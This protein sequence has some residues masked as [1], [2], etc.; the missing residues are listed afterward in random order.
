[1]NRTKR[2]TKP[3]SRRG[4]VVYEGPSMIGDRSPIVAILTWHSANRKTGDLAQ[5]WIL[6]AT[7]SPL[8]AVKANNNRGACGDCILQGRNLD[9]RQIGRTCYVNLGQAPAA[10]FSAWRRGLYL[11]WNRS[12]DRNRLKG[13][14]LRLGAYGDPAALPLWLLRALTNAAEFHTGYTHQIESLSRRRAD[15]VASLC[16]VSTETEEQRQR[17]NDRGYRTFHVVPLAQLDAATT[18]RNQIPCP[19]YSH[20]A[21]CDRCRLCGG[22]SQSAASIVVGSHGPGRGN[23][24]GT[25]A[26]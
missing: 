3:S 10:I 22:S 21:T 25:A 26:A 7:Q 8:D 17:M 16:M 13:R 5:L 4:V 23:L 1:M 12:R 20:G 2:K 11:P 24:V 18:D 6:P 9:G 14:G 19:Y 15:A